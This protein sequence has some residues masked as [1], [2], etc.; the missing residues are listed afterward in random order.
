MFRL[1]NGA[2]IT[3]G[4]APV[5]GATVSLHTYD[6]EKKT[7]ARVAEGRTDD[8]GRFQVTTYAKFDGAPA[9]E[10]LVTVTKANGPVPALYTAP[11]TT[12][13]KLRILETPNT[14]SLDLPAR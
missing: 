4:G 8:L 3:V 14:L 9:D 6:P 10:Y 7:Y 11:A 13:L 1:M 2:R 12:T 5:G